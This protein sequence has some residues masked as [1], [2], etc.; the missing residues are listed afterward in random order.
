MRNLWQFVVYN[1]LPDVDHEI[2]VKLSLAKNPCLNTREP[3]IQVLKM[4]KANDE[5]HVYVMG[6][7]MT[8]LEA[9]KLCCDARLSIE[10]WGLE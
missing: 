5:Y 7:E 2:E 9:F 10:R 8:V 4:G 3:V 6:W 1:P